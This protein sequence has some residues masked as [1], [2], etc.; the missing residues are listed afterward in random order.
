[1][2]APLSLMQTV[3]VQSEIWQTQLHWDA[4]RSYTAGPYQPTH[5]RT[6]FAISP[7]KSIYHS[8]VTGFSKSSSERPSNRKIQDWTLNICITASRTVIQLNSKEAK[9]IM[10]GYLW[11][12]TCIWVH[13]DSMC[14]H[15]LPEGLDNGVSAMGA[16]DDFDGVDFLHLQMTVYDSL[17]Y[18]S[19]VLV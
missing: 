8:V 2:H 12:F 7:V 11:L 6:H 5:V 17:W 3:K 14:S 15:Y 4:T 16:S 19:I 9:R 18:N 13:Y 1:M 10:I